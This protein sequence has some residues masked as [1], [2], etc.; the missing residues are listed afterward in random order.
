MEDC[1]I[2]FNVKCSSGTMCFE[3]RLDGK[4]IWQ[5]MVD[6]QGTDVVHAFPDDEGT[7]VM[8]LVMSGKTAA[9]TVINEQGE[10]QSDR[11]LEICDLVFDDVQ[12]GHV[13]YEK[14][15]YHHDHNSTSDPVDVGFFGTMGCNGRVSLEFSS[16][17][18]LW[19]LENH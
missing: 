5:G 2:S 7:H 1:K 11:V 12:L 19:L 14:A 10:I 8:E 13:F 4:I 16:P 3:A 6:E 18:Y 9:D 17:V 15:R